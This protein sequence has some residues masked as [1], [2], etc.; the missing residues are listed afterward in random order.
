VTDIRPV[1]PGYIEAHFGGSGPELNITDGSGGI[2]PIDSTHCGA[3][4]GAVVYVF[5]DLFGSNLR[6]V[7]EVGAHEIGHVFSLDHEFDCKDPMTYVE[8]CGDKSFVSDAQPCGESGARQC[9]CNRPS[10]S[11]VDI[12]QA[13]LGDHVSDTI[14]P[15]VELLPPIASQDVSYLQVRA[16]DPNAALRAIELHVVA[17]NIE[18]VSV[19]GDG[20]LPCTLDG[21]LASFALPPSTFDQQVWAV[22]E[23]TGGNRVSTLETVIPGGGR[24][25][26]LLAVAVAPVAAMYQPDG[27]VEI[28]ALVVDDSAVTDAVVVWTDGDGSVRT[29]PL[30]PRSHDGR[31]G[32]SMH[33]GHGEAMRS[34][35]LSITD[36][37][38]RVVTSPD[39]TVVVA[40]ST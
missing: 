40:G 20:R 24:A 18:S 13:M 2:A 3:I 36:I 25:A 26:T 21:E 37:Q 14:P 23:D 7:C 5:S 12:L 22:A 39:E 28:Q 38:G 30:C 19:C 6:S 9:I 15:T 34:F 35:H 16:H 1:T 4:D 17:N 11:S 8:G 29:I 27:I 10:Q 33:L 31:Y 32:V